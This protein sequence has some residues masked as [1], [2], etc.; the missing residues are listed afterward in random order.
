M[1]YYQIVEVDRVGGFVDSEYIYKN[2]SRSGL[3]PSSNNE[4]KT[5]SLVAAKEPEEFSN[6]LNS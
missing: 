1:R 4:P 2:P 6:K 5:P 3:N